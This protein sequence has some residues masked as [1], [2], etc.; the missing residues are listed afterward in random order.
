MN[1]L[2]WKHCEFILLRCVLPLREAH[3]DDVY[4]WFLKLE[5]SLFFCTK[6]F[7]MK[8]SYVSFSVRN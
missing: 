8:M 7:D 4:S 3:T 2:C 5:I 6:L 1:K